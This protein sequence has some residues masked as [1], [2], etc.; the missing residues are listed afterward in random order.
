MIN[1]IKI[2]AKMDVTCHNLISKTDILNALANIS[3]TLSLSLYR[4]LRF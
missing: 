3:L 4:G 1:L 2:G